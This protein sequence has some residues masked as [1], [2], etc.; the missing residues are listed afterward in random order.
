MQEQCDFQV[1]NNPEAIAIADL[2]G[3]GRPDVATA[4]YT[5]NTVSVLLNRVPT[6]DAPHPV[7]PVTPVALAF[8]PVRPNPSRGLVR[9]PFVLP[10]EMFVRLR[11]VDVLGR[12]VAVLANGMFPAGPHEVTWNGM[13]GDRRAPTGVYF[14][15]LEADGRQIG[16]RVVLA[17]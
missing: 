9:A 3:D 1:G 8:A 10:H 11:V 6:L 7:T 16:R 12:N 5:A 17:R 4:N 14:M 2:N 13:D 15:N